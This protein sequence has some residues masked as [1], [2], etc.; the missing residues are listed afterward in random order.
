MPAR[1]G[2]EA[3]HGADRLRHI[4]LLGGV[5][6]RARHPPARDRHR[7]FAPRRRLRH[8]LG[9]SR[10]RQDHARAH[11]HPLSRRRRG[12]RGAEPDLHA[13]ADLRAAAVS[14]GPRRPLP[15]IGAGRARRA[16]L[17]RLA[18]RRGGAARVARPRGRP[19][20]ARSARRFAHAGAQAQARIPPRPHHRLWRAGAARRPHGG[21]APIHRRERLQRS[22]AGAVARRRLDALVRAA[23]ARRSTRAA[24][25]FAAP[26][27]RPAGAGRQA[28]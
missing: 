16:R 10:R 1:T 20:A 8:A 22:A 24:D 18:G 12:D 3:C 17:R 4:E 9:R 23:R 6:R 21:G 19:F 15:A 2:V 5:A 25:E 11:A 28:L 26:A 27:R 14:V 7:Q 13:D